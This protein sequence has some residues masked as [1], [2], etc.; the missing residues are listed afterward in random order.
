MYKFLAAASLFATIVLAGSI[1]QAQQVAM[2]GQF[3]EANGIIIN[4]PQNPPVVACTQA[5]DARCMKRRLRRGHPLASAPWWNTIVGNTLIDKPQIGV[6]AA[7]IIDTVGGASGLAVGDAFKIPTMA[8][9]QQNPLA[10]APVLDNAV[11]QLDTELTAAGPRSVRT[12]LVGGAPVPLTR[13]FSAGNWSAVGNGHDN[14]RSTMDPNYHH[15]SMDATAGG[16]AVATATFGVYQVEV[17]YELGPN[18]FGGTMATLLDGTGRLFL[19]YAGM[20]QQYGALAPV[21]ARNPIGDA[22]PGLAVRNGGGWGFTRIGAQA[23]GTVRSFNA[24]PT[25]VAPACSPGIIPPTPIGCNMVNWVEGTTMGAVFS[26]FAPASQSLAGA[27]NNGNRIAPFGSANSVKFVH[28]WTTGNVTVHRTYVSGRGL[29]VLD[30]M[31]GMGYDTVGTTGSGA[32][33][34]N[35]GMVA[36]SYTKRTDGSGNQAINMQ[37]IAMNLKFTPEPGATVALLSGL[38]LLGAFAA[39]RRS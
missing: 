8:F 27:A 11:R 32:P 29:T 35:V 14:G 13:Q 12:N 38:G 39:R 1:G 5:G 20:T 16:D 21:V 9:V 30:T 18:A 31:T 15:R 33:Q 19:D 28:P 22:A 7:Q 4:I 26:A 36:G 24:T 17:S 3:H 6:K 25:A 34:R 2:A 37:M 10:V 23:H